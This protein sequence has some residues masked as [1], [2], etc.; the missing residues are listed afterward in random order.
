[1][2]AIFGG[3]Y[4]FG[5]A[6]QFIAEAKQIQYTGLT[7]TLDSIRRQKQSTER[8]LGTQKV[9][10][11]AYVKRR[12]ELLAA[13]QSSSPG[14]GRNIDENAEYDKKLLESKVDSKAEELRNLSEAETRAAEKI[15]DAL[16][17]TND[18]LVLTLTTK[19]GSVLL[20]LFFARI[21]VSIFRYYVRLSMFYQSRADVLALQHLDLPLN[22]AELASLLST[23]ALDFE[24]STETLSDSYIPFV[25]QLQALHEKTNVSKGAA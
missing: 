19:I 12:A 10:L 18:Q 17:P 20:L 24:K 7:A 11:D 13:Q 16:A 3:I 15:K 5:F 8:E 2:I 9:Q 4:V 14:I 23:E 25:K 21:L 22:L 1:M 6:S